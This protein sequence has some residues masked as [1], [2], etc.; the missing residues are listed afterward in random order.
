MEAAA[1]SQ[2][3]TE[4]SSREAS[5]ARCITMP[6]VIGSE[7]TQK[8]PVSKH[9]QKT[10][11]AHSRKAQFAP[12]RNIFGYDIIH[13]IYLSVCA[14]RAFSI[15]HF[16]LPAMDRSSH[17]GGGINFCMQPSVIF[18]HV[19][20]TRARRKF[21]LSRRRARLQSEARGASDP[22]RSASSLGR[23]KCDICFCKGRV[24]T[25]P[26]LENVHE[27]SNL[28]RALSYSCGLAPAMVQNCQHVFIKEDGEKCNL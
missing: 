24:G 3:N 13:F 11:L 16:T 17:W 25:L 9:P 1:A 23:D 27:K 7:N 19:E 4:I 10:I 22:P 6:T 26:N 5:R 20:D 8:S 2:V 12:T 18:I 14:A 28:T 15:L 21:V